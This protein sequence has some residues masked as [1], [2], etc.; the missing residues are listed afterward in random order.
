MEATTEAKR[1]IIALLATSPPLI[2]PPFEGD[3]M[4][5]KILLSWRE[6][7]HRWRKR[8]RGK[9]YNWPL[10]PGE[11]KT[12]SRLRCEKEWKEIKAK[13]DFEKTQQ[14]SIPDPTWAAPHFPF[15]P[16]RFGMQFAPDP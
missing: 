12:T 11:T 14:Q 6:T 3:P 5:R 13:I 16:V 7:E 8:Y 15:D 9:Y 4:A 1:A 10:N 2:K